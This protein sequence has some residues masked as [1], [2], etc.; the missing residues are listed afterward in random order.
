MARVVKALGVKE[1]EKISKMPGVHAVGGV[2]GFALRVWASA[3]G[4]GCAWILRTE[5]KGKETKVTV[6]TYP[7]MGLHAARAKAAE[8]KASLLAGVNPVKEARAKVKAEKK[9][10]EVARLQALTVGDVLDEWL[11]YKVEHG[12]W[13]KGIHEKAEAVAH[14]E[15]RRI[16]QSAALLLGVPVASC[17]PEDVVKAIEPIWCSK[18]ATCETVCSHLRGL[19]HWAMTVK[20]CRP[21]GINPADSQWLTPLLPA[22][23]KRKQE[24]H[25]P[26]LD[27]DQLPQLIKALMALGSTSALCTAFAILTCTR[28][29]N[30]RS[31]R[32]DQ[33][34]EDGQLWSIDAIDMKV[35]ANGQHLIPLSAEAQ[36]IIQH[37]REFSLCLDSPYVF[38]SYR[39]NGAPL[40]NMTMNVLIQRLHSKEVAEGREG[41]IDR[42]QTK[43]KG[44]PV[45]AVQHAISRA[46]FESWA[47]GTRQDEHAVAL[48]LHHDVDPRLKSAYDRSEDLPH[49]RKVL[50]AWGK[51]CFSECEN[52]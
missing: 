25:F 49:K 38:G 14:K 39:N 20:K 26:A 41:W 17:E 24:E 40:S 34:S 47:Q 29:N 8:F 5:C 31:M 46:T 10:E 18:R 27:P 11:A 6:G 22:E 4:S 50:D 12:T 28:S 7:E 1:V 52:G 15:G 32:W 42:K 48:I 19:F 33:I 44:K 45:I 36:R 30:V 21:R 16:R 9:A 23:N 2:P 13:G 51:F 37:Q 43:D 3:A 35:T